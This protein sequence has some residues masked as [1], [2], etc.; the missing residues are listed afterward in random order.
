MTSRRTLLP[1]DYY[2][3]PVCKPRRPRRATLNLGQALAGD[4]V[5]SSV[6][7]INILE[8]LYCKIVCAVYVESSGRRASNKLDK[9]IRME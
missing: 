1:I 7:D 9:A 3:L 5:Q 4:L 2:Q 8:E 6:Y